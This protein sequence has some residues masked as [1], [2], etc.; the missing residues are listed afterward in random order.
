MGMPVKLSDELVREARE[1]ARVVNRS[2]TGQIEHWATPRYPSDRLD[3]G[4]KRG[5][6]AHRCGR[7]TDLRI[8][9]GS[10]RPHRSR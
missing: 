6:S 4:S 1:E 3:V 8:R 7:G 10:P 2:I 5:Q 9:S